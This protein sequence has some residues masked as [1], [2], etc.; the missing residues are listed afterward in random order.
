MF[1]VLE[2]VRALTT[3]DVLLIRLC[4]LALV[5]ISHGLRRERRT[6]NITRRVHRP[7]QR[8]TFPSEQIVSMATKPCPDN[9][10]CQ[11][12]ESPRR[13]LSSKKCV[14][15]LVAETPHEWLRA[16]LG[17]IFGVVELARI[18]DR[19]VHQ[20]W[21]RDWV[22]FRAWPSRI[23]SAGCWVGHMVRVI[24]GIK[25][26]AVPASN[27]LS[28]CGLLYRQFLD[29]T[30][31]GNRMFAMTAIHGVSYHYLNAIMSV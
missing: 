18:P 9:P 10:Y 21:H 26:L 15:S 31:V 24:H 1:Q 17:P 13:R 29:C 14:Y 11:S 12:K 28:A 8:I 20:L 19:L 3:I 5:L 23:K 22:G 30:Y 25:I 27:S 4:N 7:L 16:V 2:G 6:I